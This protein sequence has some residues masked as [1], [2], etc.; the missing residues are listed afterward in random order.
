[1]S[2]TFDLLKLDY[3]RWYGHGKRDFFLMPIRFFTLDRLNYC[4][5]FRNG[6][7]LYR[8]HGFWKILYG[9]VS[10]IHTHNKHRLG[11]QIKLG[12]DIG[13]GMRFP[14][15]SGIVLAMCKIGNN[16]TIHQ[17]VTIG[18]T[19]GENDGCP[20][21]GDNVIIFANSSIVGNIKVG[22]NVIIGANSIVIK[23]VPDNSVVAGNPAKIIS[24]DVE[25]C[26]SKRW[27]RY[28]YGY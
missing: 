10:V 25:K 18:R 5:W 20:I 6:N 8:K 7:A 2:K 24:N 22:N 14:H 12:T 23:D 15:Y 21:I 27:E 11:I 9:I 26:I 1:M 3:H 19:F 13:G 16:C 4:L 28:F 17:N